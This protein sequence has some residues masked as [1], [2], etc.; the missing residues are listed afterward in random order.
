ML[1][2]NINNF[3]T[4]LIYDALKQRREKNIVR[5]DVLHLLMEAQKGNLKTE[6][7]NADTSI[8]E[9]FA[10]KNELTIDKTNTKTDISDLDIAAQAMVFFFAGLDS[11]SSLMCFMAYELAVNPEIQAKL[12]AEITDT[13]ENSNGK[14]TY[15]TLTKMKYMDMV[16]NGK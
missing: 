1:G 6:H 2:E 4:S 10:N 13:Y 14:V 3:F 7:E 5:M 15:E 11:V 8:S 9:S 12:R 16:V